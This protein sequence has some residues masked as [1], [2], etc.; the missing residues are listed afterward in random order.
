MNSKLT[1]AIQTADDASDALKSAP[2][3]ARPTQRYQQHQQLPQQW[4]IGRDMA[5]V[6]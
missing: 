2:A 1:A 4:E 6:T 5:A 3:V